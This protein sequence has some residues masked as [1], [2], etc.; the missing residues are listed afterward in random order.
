[1]KTF[2][3]KITIQSKSSWAQ[4]S[5]I[6]ANDSKYSS[7]L[8]IILAMV[9]L[10]KVRD[11]KGKKDITFAAGLPDGVV[12]EEVKIELAK[13]S[14]MKTSPYLL[15]DLTS[16]YSID[17]LSAKLA[18]FHNK[19]FKTHFSAN[20]VRFTAGSTPVIHAVAGITQSIG[21][22]AVVISP[23]YP[24]YDLPVEMYGGS[25]NKEAKFMPISDEKNDARW[26]IDY[27]SLKNV[28]KKVTPS[29][30][31]LN[32]P[33]NP[34]GYAPTL[35]ESKKIVKILLEHIQLCWNTG[36]RAPLILEDIAYATMMHDKKRFYGIHNAISYFYSEASLEEKKLL[37][38]LE[39]SLVVVHSFSKAFAIAGDRAGYF[40]TLNENLYDEIS[41]KMTVID[42]TFGRG[43]LAAVTGALKAGDVNLNDMHEYQKRIRHFEIELNNVIYAWAEK[44][45]IKNDFLKYILPVQAKADAGFFSLTFFDLLHGQ[46]VSKDIIDSIHDQ[47]NQLS[48]NSKNEFLNIFE[49]GKINNSID[50]AL[51]LAEKAGVIAVPISHS[52]K[53]MLRFS[54]GQTPI[55]AISEGLRRIQEAI[56]EIYPASEVFY[57]DMIAQQDLAVIATQNFHQSQTKNEVALS[58]ERVIVN[59]PYLSR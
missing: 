42:L 43:A 7:P 46:E 31:Y 3:R 27:A 28:L 41:R 24:L 6:I 55:P 51:W 32:F 58:S 21:S 57:N 17:N 56:K 38:E 29:L 39:Q 53:L 4:R 2:T 20:Q 23:S 44:R 5:A 34:T 30:I 13:M 50:A 52:E 26:G 54:V 8:G 48:E 19:K 59:R 33:G 12:P 37:H 11:I 1:M 16:E 9:Q 22:Q 35:E 15:Y 10:K 49:N 45:N 47:I 18:N 40:V 14:H 36:I 25:I